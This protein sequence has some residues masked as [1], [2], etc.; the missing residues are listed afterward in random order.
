M[1][2]CPS[3]SAIT[4][5]ANF[6]CTKGVGRPRKWREDCV[7]QFSISV[8]LLDTTVSDEHIRAVSNF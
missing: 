3:G 2:I 7:K 8:E 6:D 1:N 5:R 4:Y